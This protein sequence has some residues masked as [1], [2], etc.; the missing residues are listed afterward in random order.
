M[1]NTTNWYL[2]TSC[3]SKKKSEEI[4]KNQIKN[5]EMR[6]KIRKI[7]KSIPMLEFLV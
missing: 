4:P 2:Y 6:R 5:E 3:A 7:K 1:E